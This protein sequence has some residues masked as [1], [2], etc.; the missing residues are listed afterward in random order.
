MVVVGKGQ[1]IKRLFHPLEGLRDPVQV[2]AGIADHRC[3]GRLTGGLHNADQA[4]L[5]LAFEQQA[6]FV[7]GT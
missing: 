7:P 6:L 1:G 5:G 2:R 4:P 3:E